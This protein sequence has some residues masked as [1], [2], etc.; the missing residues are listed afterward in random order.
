VARVRYV[1]N[2]GAN[3]EQ[4]YSFNNNPS[5]YIW[6]VTKGVAKPTGEFA[7][8]AMRPFDKTTFGTLNEFRK[9]GWS[10]YSGMLF[11]IERRYNKFAAFQLAYLVGNTLAT[12]LSNQGSVGA[13]SDFLPG[14][15]PEDFDARNRFLT[16]RRD[17]FP[18]KHRVK[19]N[20]L[21]DLPFGKGKPLFGN[22]NSTLDRI[23][24][25]WQVSG[26]GAIRSNHFSLPT[27]IYPVTGNAIEIYGYDYPIQDCRSGVCQPGYL[28][29]NG[30]IPSHQINSVDASGKPNGVMGVP[31]SYKPA[32][33]PLIPHNTPGVAANLQGTNTVWVPLADGRVQQVSF[34]DNLHP[35]RQQ[36]LPA[37]RQWVMDA[38]VVKNIPITESWRCRF[39]VDFFNVFNT[40]GN[41][42][43]GSGSEGILSTRTSAQDA[44]TL[45]A[46]LRISW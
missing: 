14:A 25:G 45:Q 43:M 29:W 24:G 5:D 4:F 21:V 40:P 28:W 35:W 9:T 12:A 23:V 16:Y 42:M 6:Y 8:V 38:G 26:I 11:E 13:V 10:N 37:N 20:F 32:A 34:N 2:H 36:F 17:T 22:V 27:G 3:L 41:P 44:R 18:P 31:S 19:W 39:S 33:Q 15:V 46:S 7:P 1:G 30:Y